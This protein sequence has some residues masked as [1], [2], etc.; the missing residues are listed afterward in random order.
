MGFGLSDE[1]LP[2]DPLPESEQTPEVP[3]EIAPLN[4]L[5]EPE[6][7]QEAALVIRVRAPRSP[8]R[9]DG[10]AVLRVVLL[11]AVL[12]VAG[13]LR[14][15]DQNWD[16]Y[17][18]L[19]PDERF[20]TQVIGNMNGPLQFEAAAEDPDAHLQ[21]CIA[22][23]PSTTDASGLPQAGRGGYFD[24]D[25]SPLNPNNVGY[26][27]YVYGE[28][29][30]F[31]VRLAG[32]ARTQLSYDYGSYLAAFDPDAAASY[33]PATYWTGYNGA[34]LVGRTVSAL[35]D[36]LTTLLLF[37][38]GRQLYGDWVGLLAAALYG[39]AAFPIQ[40]SQ[41]WTVDAFTTMWVTL[42]IYFAART[43]MD[44]SVRRGPLPLPY[45]GVW[46]IG[47]GWE[48]AYWHRPVLGLVTLAAIFGVVLL[49]TLGLS[50]LARAAGKRWGDAL[51]AASGV[52]ASLVYLIGWTV[53]NTTAQSD[54]AL[55][56]GIIALG[57]S[58][59]LF[60]LVTLATYA[61]SVA[62][63]HQA[64]FR[65]YPATTSLAMGAVGGSWLLLVAALLLDGVAPWST[66]LVALAASALLVADVTEIT[67]YVLFGVA[68]G[69]AVA[70]RVNVAPLAAL[71]VV[72]A[73]LR[74]L[75][76]LDVKLA[77]EQRTRL[78]TRAISGLVAAAVVSLVVFRLLQPHAFMGPGLFGLKINSGWWNDLQEAS[79]QQS[80]QWDVPP[81]F[82]W[83]DRTNYLFPWRNIV[84]W[85]LGV[86]L[87]LVA[88]AA[89]LWAG[90]RIIRGKRR[91]VQHAI[92]FV[93]ILGYFGWLGGRWVTT[94]R[95]FLPVYPALVL[96]GAWGLWSLASGAWRAMRARPAT[97]RRLA[98]AGATALLVAVYAYTALFGYGMHKI[99]AKQLTRVAA[100]RWFQEFVPGDFGV[101]VEGDDG[102]RQLVN[103]GVTYVAPIARVYHMAQGDTYEFSADP[104]Q[105]AM[106][107]ALGETASLTPLTF[108]EGATLE[109]ITF[110]RLGDPDRDDEAETVRVR[111]L[112]D[113]PALGRQV[114]YEDTVEMDLNGGDSPY[115]REV[116]LA[117]GEDVTFDRTP[118]TDG[119]I[120]G[121][122]LQITAL[123]GGPVM[124]SHGL[125]DAT[126]IAL[127]DVSVAV[128][129]PGGAVSSYDF[130]LPDQPLLHGYGDDIPIDPTQWTLNGRDTISFAVPID[131]TISAVEIPHLGDVLGDADAESV[132]LTVETADGQ[133]SSA[134]VTDDFERSADPLG[135]ARTVALDTPLH[136]TARDAAG[137]PVMVT[138]VIE[139]H[140]PIYT[141]GPVVAW[142]GS[143]DDPVPWPVCPLPD[144]MVYTDDAPSGLSSLA[145]QSPGM[146]G[147]H[148][149]GIQLWMVA[150][151][152][153]S[154]FDAM[155]LALDQADY[156]VITS[157]RF[158]DTLTRLPMRWPMS[159]R[160]YDALF[161]GD[162]GYELIK[163]FESY[164]SVGPVTIPDEI[165]P[166]DDLPDWLNEQ[167][168]AEEAY[169]VYDHPVVY[170]FRKQ[171]AYSSD[172][173]RAVLEGSGG[174][175]AVST[176]TASY[177][178]DPQPVEVVPW[179]S[180]QV[181][182]SPTMLQLDH[183]KRAIQRDGGTWSDLFD[184]G[185]LVNRSQVAAV[186][187]WWLLM[188]VAGWLV[189]PLLFVTL[190]ALPDRG[191]P[192]AKL[193][194]WLLVAWVAWAGGTLNILTWTR[195][196]LAALLVGLAA[197]SGLLI[198]W[199]RVEFWRYIR[200]HWRHLLA[201]EILTGVLFAAFLGVRLGNP[202]L[203]HSA[204]GGEKPMDFAYFNAVLRSTVFP[205]ID[206]WNAGGYMNYYYFGYVIVGA[207]V[208]LIGVR[209]AVAY[210]LILPTLY[211]MTGVAVFSIAYNWV[212]GR[213]DG[214]DPR[215]ARWWL[216]LPRGNAWLAGISAM[217]LAVVMGNL[218][219]PLEFVRQVSALDG[220]SQR[221]PLSEVIRAEQEAN[222][223]E[224]F[225]A[226]YQDALEDFRDEYGYEPTAPGDALGVQQQA[227]TETDDAIN[228]AALH[229]SLTRVWSYGF[230]NLRDQ[231]GSFF[232]G[233]EKMMSGQQLQV[234]PNR[235]YWGPRSIIT[236]LPNGTGG[237]AIAEMPYFTFVYGDLHAHMLSMP[238]YLFALLWLLAEVMGAGRSGRR[239]WESSLALAL[240]G[241]AVGVLRPTNSWDWITFLILGPLALTYA[242]WVGAVR[243][244]R[245]LPPSRL[246]A[247]LWSRLRPDR[248]LGLWPVLLVVPVAVA[249]R[250]GYYMVRSSQEADQ[251]GRMLQV[252]EKAIHATLTLPSILL[253]ILGG[254]VLTAVL[255]VALVVA[256]RA[257]INKP[258][259]LGW[260]GGIA[261]FVGASVVAALP[262]TRYFATAYTSVQP[263]TQARTPLWAYLYIHGTFLFI[264]ACFLLWQT[265]RILR[266]VHVRD[267]EGLA[268]PVLLAGAAAVSGVIVCVVIGAHD[269]PALQVSGP[270]LIWA[271]VLFFVPGQHPCLR[272]M[273]PL[274]VLGL[275]LTL[276]V[277]L[278]VLSGDIGRQNTVFK[279]Y[280]QAW[281]FFSVVS[282]VAVAWMLHA[283]IR[284]QPVL[285]VAWQFALVVLLTVGLLYPILAT[286]GRF[287]D[288]FNAAETPLTLDGM[289]Y[290]KYTTHGENGVWFS[291]EDDYQMIR[292][293]QD[294]VEG[295][296]VVME[297]HQYPSEYHWNGR[298]SIY[299]GLPT[300]LGWRFHQIQQ[301]SLPSMDVLIQT[302]EN[303]IIAFYQMTGAGGIEAAWNLI[304]FYD[305]EYVVVGL[306]E[307]AVYGDIVTD[308]TTGLQTA[309]HAASLAKF[310][311]M[312]DLGLL[313]VVYEDPGCLLLGAEECPAESVYLNKVYHVVPGATLPDSFALSSPA[314]ETVDVPLG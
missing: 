144:D 312:V 92:P 303:N 272:L 142:E 131:G 11:V 16:D 271:M 91:W 22:R 311:Q 256:L 23:Y 180:I 155:M 20:L 267:L 117:P 63:R 138:L 169:H 232:A 12:A 290:M 174:L 244:N 205:P 222:R 135:P 30:L 206:P 110:H 94:M 34:Q 28:F 173:A 115:G 51:V 18:H 130:N 44:A 88:W 98:F 309:G 57:V 78:I 56:N 276:G 14:L 172:H 301:H 128:R 285:R 255:Y 133:N 36:L 124:F 79:F 5:P 2:V 67:D 283:S 237:N 293:F 96:F 93:W 204:F 258:R 37:L 53:L 214:D 225:N 4:V 176:A 300:I 106:T 1:M 247:R 74:V 61:A 148:Y 58:S 299:T 24:A 171:A 229:P 250:L 13:W 211:A 287:L 188:I 132:T 235:W 223:Q 42:G 120:A 288:R 70:S 242:A 129:E 54:F 19:H 68:L 231:I 239:W 76:V 306:L 127:S 77:P 49:I 261:L 268:V 193:V 186:L 136:V 200:A 72:A 46:A 216:P 112:Y 179:A 265:M 184:M 307:R 101:W 166:I 7:P 60:A 15:T 241:L 226:H 87:G 314:G 69:G 147:S 243:A 140:D 55:A 177:V 182:K 59:L 33:V 254:F 213:R 224:I 32:E 95:Y 66:L 10:W 73:A 157:N 118:P 108:T 29:P 8:L 308:P 269:V 227:Q 257:Y 275:A 212:K 297:A 164:P 168:E 26:G 160:F 170:V 189:W 114:I 246:A 286:Q 143:W 21:R 81:N 215:R 25:C 43:L 181:D 85:G 3:E 134:T 161:G 31:T 194:A 210:N 125:T 154:K 260:L 82:Q 159:V 107:T 282:G 123:D 71:I 298:I 145:C 185:S 259:L 152:N 304:D 281:F 83:V 278:V 89:W 236:E 99:H 109:G 208:K 40:Q 274:M 262:F 209:P 9:V 90:L 266:R 121:Y 191:Y 217:V 270:L 162:M 165:L 103:L 104:R 196:G 234:A 146:Y 149:Q 102:T 253:W 248:V 199:R 39:V 292:W 238:V 6:P 175:R 218:G 119:T 192:V 302:R 264:I 156:L 137:N 291:L 310:D 207:P 97:G 295:S 48:T 38:L 198:W 86:P 75:P 151:D 111:I 113:D 220:Y 183:E 251:A 64:L 202:D 65:S 277:E 195:P 190:P 150:E 41:F 197:L 279:F 296:P 178:A 221:T 139:A 122:V 240:G 35:C 153:S 294:N 163:T 249:A 313:D 219:I 52:V 305:V 201:V 284:W 233:L 17:T 245:D 289:E 252:G 126:G 80:G 273:Y 84:E 203:W 116:A 105:A 158:Y 280:L 141:S 228:A 62:V 167:W 263:W 27:F 230:N 50:V 47:A 187:I 100:S 45:L